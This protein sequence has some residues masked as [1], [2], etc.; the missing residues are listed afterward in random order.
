[1]PV[2]TGYF[3][4]FNAAHHGID[5]VRNVIQLL[6][7]GINIFTVKRSDK[8]FVELFNNGMACGIAFTLKVQ[9]LLIG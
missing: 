8:R 7:K 5:H 4:N 9:D 2:A 1:M 3:I 6:G